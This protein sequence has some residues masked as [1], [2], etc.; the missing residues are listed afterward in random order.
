MGFVVNH[1]K[2]QLI[3]TCLAHLPF[4]QAIYL[5][6]SWATVDEKASSD[7]DI[8]LLFPVQEARKLSGLY[9]TPLHQA[10]E[11]LFSKNIDLIN[12]RQVSTVLQKEVIS[13]EQRIYCADNNAADEFEMLT[14]SYYQKLNEERADILQSFYASGRAIRI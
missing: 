4:I 14:I 11:K 9:T 7:I 6:G 13:A 5:F 12:L 1:E 10:L 3:Q 2:Q 8:A